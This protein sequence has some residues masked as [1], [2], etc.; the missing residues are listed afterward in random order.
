MKIASCPMRPRKQDAGLTL[1]ELVVV[2]A[3]LVALAG[4]VTP[5]LMSTANTARETATQASAIEIRNATMQYWSDCKHNIV[6]QR[7]QVAHLL[8]Q[9]SFLLRFDPN[10]RLGWNGPYLQS[11]GR[12]YTV[13]TTSGFDTSY[14]DASQL[15]IRDAFASQDYDGDGSAES[16]SPFV[17]QEPTLRELEAASQTYS[18]GQPREIR[19]V[20]AGP[21]GFI[22][23]D[24]EY[25]ATQLES[26]ESLKGDDIYVTFVVR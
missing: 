3:I 23:I 26:N 24:E 17:I 2:L 15:S 10:V 8:N 16:G 9:P 6:D 25:T 11:D 1:V 4:F 22:E 7:I 14:G 5:R 18:L 21:N 19:V 12:T 13:D 20:S